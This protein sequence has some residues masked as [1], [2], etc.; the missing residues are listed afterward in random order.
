MEPDE[1]DKAWEPTLK[2]VMEI[3][4]RIDA[5]VDL[6][7]ERLSVLENDVAILKGEKSLAEE[8][9]KTEGIGSRSS[10]KTMFER[11]VEEASTAPEGEQ[12]LSLIHI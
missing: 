10:R 5:K 6:N 7:S 12:R 1:K 4:R 11:E 3:L 2:D 8:E 9:E